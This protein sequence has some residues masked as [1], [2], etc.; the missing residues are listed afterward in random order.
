MSVPSVGRESEREALL[1]RMQS[2]CVSIP[3]RDPAPPLALCHVPHELYTTTTGIS[4]CNTS[5]AQ[6]FFCSFDYRQRPARFPAQNSPRPSKTP[7]RPQ[8][9]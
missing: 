7:P 1:T 2:A 6:F 3:K 5:C 9:P 4:F 8:L